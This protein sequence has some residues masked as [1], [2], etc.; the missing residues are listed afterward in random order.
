MVNHQPV[1][2]YWIQL[3]QASLN[4]AAPDNE[5]GNLQECLNAALLQI[6]ST[7]NTMD[8]LYYVLTVFI[9]RRR[10]NYNGK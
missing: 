9:W 7:N 4:S 8:C 2:N 6:V 10:P 3:S 5:Q 1:R